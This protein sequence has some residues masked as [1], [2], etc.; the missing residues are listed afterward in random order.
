MAPT[1][2]ERETDA[3]MTTAP[4]TFATRNRAASARPGSAKDER[5]EEIFGA[6]FNGRVIRRF[7]GFMRPYRGRLAIAIG[8]VVVF[9]VTQLSIPL[10]I[11]TVIDKALATGAMDEHLLTIAALVFLAVISVN[12]LASLGHEVIVG[13]TGE[14]ILFDLRRAMYAHIQRLSLSFMDKTEVGRLM[15]RLQGDVG[16]LQE[17]LDTTVTSIGDIL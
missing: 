10:V 6:A 4:L 13:K 16:S 5:D 3:V 2:A 7:I 17:F 12:A 15:S 9:T 11:K 8:C 1:P 14:R